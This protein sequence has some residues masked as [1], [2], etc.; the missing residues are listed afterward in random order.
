MRTW[1]RWVSPYLA[2]LC[3]LGGLQRFGQRHPVLGAIDRGV[4]RDHPK[5]AGTFFGALLAHPIGQLVAQD[6]RHVTHGR[7]VRIAGQYL[8]HCDPVQQAILDQIIELVT[9]QYS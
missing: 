7:V 4:E 9:L 2:R 8:A 1:W 5:V 6:L 3:G